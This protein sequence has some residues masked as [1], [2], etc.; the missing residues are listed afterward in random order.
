[1]GHLDFSH[2]FEVFLRNESCDYLLAAVVR[3]LK[4]LCFGV[5]VGFKFETLFELWIF[6]E[7]WSAKKL[8]SNVTI[9]EDRAINF[10][11]LANFG[12]SV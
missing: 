7:K 1:M 4:G 10:L 12:V 3:A 2:F 8:N 11:R 5:F 9:T 6:P